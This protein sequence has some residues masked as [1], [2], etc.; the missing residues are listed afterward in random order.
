MSNERKNQGFYKN[1]RSYFSYFNHKLYDNPIFLQ[2]DEII[3]NSNPNLNSFEEESSSTSSHNNVSSINN[4]DKYIPLNLLD[5]SPLKDSLPQEV[6]APKNSEKDKNGQIS[7]IIKPDMEKY[8][9]EKEENINLNISSSLILSNSLNLSSE[10]FT[11]KYKIVPY[12]LPN[13]PSYFL[14]NHNKFNIPN[15][16]NNNIQKKD[17]INNGKKKKKKNKTFVE[18]EGDWSCYRCKNLNFSFRDICNKC[19]MSKDES[20]KKFIEVGEELLKLAD[21]SIYNK[22]K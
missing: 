6:I 13:N 7:S 22:S 16:N 18:R 3:I 4:E 20:E 11:P 8:I 21:L 17:Y 12:I 9:S 2:D 14:Y 19:Q 15:N 1:D 10:P 5:L